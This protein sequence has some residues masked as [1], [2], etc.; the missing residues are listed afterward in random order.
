VATILYS[1]RLFPD[2]SVEREIFG[3]D[4][5]VI[6]RDVGALA[7]LDPADCAEVEGLMNAGHRISATD[8][9]KF[10]KLRAI[11]RMA[12]G[13]DLVDRKEAARRGILVCNTPDYG[14]TE[15]AD[16][17]MALVLALR[18]GVLLHH[19]RQ[20]ATPPA[21]WRA[22]ATPLIR[23]SGVQGFGIIGLG[24]IGTAVALRAKAFGFTVLFFDPY[25][26]SGTELAL[27]ITRARA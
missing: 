23:R 16:H 3:A 22:I 20:R 24:R 9:A 11:V 5:R 1:Q 2:D 8:M 18:R 21:A 12:V 10:P 14:T 17:A 26:P 19:D 13:Y 6:V 27:G 4:T 25:V 15:V 7:E